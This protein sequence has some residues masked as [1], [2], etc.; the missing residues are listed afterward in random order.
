M[1]MKRELINV[2]I[3]GF[4]VQLATQVA[5]TCKK[6]GFNVC[7]FGIAA[8]DF[9]K[10]SMDIADVGKLRMLRFSDKN[11]KEKL[12]AEVDETKRENRF[13][14]VADVS[15]SAEN[16]E[17][18]NSVKVPFV[19]QSTDHKSR[20]AANEKSNQLAVIADDFNKY[21]VAFDAIMREWGR[22]FP[23]LFRGFEIVGDGASASRHLA[24]SFNDLLDKPAEKSPGDNPLRSI[25]GRAHQEFTFK[26]GAGSATFSFKRSAGPEDYAEG[27][28]DAIQ[29]LAA[30]A[31][32]QSPARV[33]SMVDVAR[34]APLM[35]L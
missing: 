2:I 20:I 18:Y 23:G 14:V 3:A 4:P 11:L 35:M 34:R 29:F 6:R 25:E 16:I 5:Q 30:Q 19:M 22:R 13:P 24:H 7:K 9:D 28:A 12:I 31:E 17:L 32:Q 21:S 8:K 27:M 33:F 10:D 15:D 1:R 26:N